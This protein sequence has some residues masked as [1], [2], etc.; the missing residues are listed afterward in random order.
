MSRI[1][2]SSDWGEPALALLAQVKR[3]DPSKPAVLHIRHTEAFA[4]SERENSK[5][6]QQNSRGRQAAIE[7]GEQLPLTRRY[8]FF[9]SNNGRAKETAE[10]IA[11]GIESRGGLATVA[12][13]IPASWALDEKASEAYTQEF[14]KKYGEP[15]WLRRFVYSWI[16]GLAPPKVARPSAEFAELVAEYTASNSRTARLDTVDIYISHD[17]WVAALLFHWFAEPVPDDG[18]RFLDGFMMQPRDSGVTL[19]VRGKK[20]QAEYPY[21]WAKL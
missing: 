1:L 6:P 20:T 11:T 2:S 10:A 13:V 16:A 15:A 21:W 8:R 7:Y 12:G 4:T 3:L 18:I 9:H 5:M 14:R 19:Y 17:T